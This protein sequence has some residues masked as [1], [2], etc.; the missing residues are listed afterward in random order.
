MLLL[1]QLEM[2]L[3]HSFA[4]GVYLREIE[5]PA[6]AFVLGHRHKTEHFNIILTGKALV[7]YDGVVR[8]IKAPAYF[9]SGRDC[10]KVLFI[11]EDMRWI[12]VHMTDETD[13]DKLEELLIEKSQTFLDHEI[14]DQI[15]HL[16]GAI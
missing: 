15:L 7:A 14:E 3:K 13:I 2:P 16:K 4:P 8:E 6:G 1:P 12:T 10:R 5:M 9:V 11:Q